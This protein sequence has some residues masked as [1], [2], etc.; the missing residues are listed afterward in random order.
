MGGLCTGG[1]GGGT[2]RRAGE[3]LSLVLTPSASIVEADDEE[4]EDSRTAERACFCLTTASSGVRCLVTGGLPCKGLACLTR[5]VFLEDRATPGEYEDI[6]VGVED[7][8]KG[9][10]DSE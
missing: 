2:G 9:P 3:G 4:V 6:D 5:V 8:L 7:T 1:V 10:G